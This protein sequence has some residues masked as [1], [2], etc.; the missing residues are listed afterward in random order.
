MVLLCLIWGVG[1]VAAKIA[2]HGISFVFQSGLRSLVAAVLL[3]LWV[4]FR[5]I[6]LWERD[7][8]LWPGIFAGLLFA[9]EFVFIFSGLGMTDA[10]RIVVFVYLAPC[11]T[12]F[13]LHFLIPQER[14]SARQWAGI[15]LAFLGVAVAF[16]D[17]FLGGRGTL[18]GDFFGL[19][20]AALWAATTI[21]IR[22]TRLASVSARSASAS[23]SSPP[24]SISAAPSSESRSAR[25]GSSSASNPVARSSSAIAAGRSLRASARRPADSSRAEARSPTPVSSAAGRRPARQRY[26]CSRW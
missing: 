3:L 11:I 4:Y 6:P 18:L 14:L 26:A 21:L 25:L 9:A 8:T 10:A 16:G 13:G 15:L 23:C 17:G 12:A 7:R 1:N 24:A 5:K 2:G 19:V 22:S 20:G